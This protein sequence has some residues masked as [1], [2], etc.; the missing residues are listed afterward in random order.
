MMNATYANKSFTD[1][2]IC[3]IMSYISSRLIIKLNNNKE[4][5]SEW[6]KYTYHC[7]QLKTS[8]HKT[9]QTCLR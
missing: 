4:F 5:D 8:I 6:H 9:T 2:T 7:A 1:K 3:D